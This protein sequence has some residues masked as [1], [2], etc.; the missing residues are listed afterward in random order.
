MSGSDK[1]MALTV[2]GEIVNGD[3]W[4]GDGDSGAGESFYNNYIF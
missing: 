4:C 1:N 2:R 3:E